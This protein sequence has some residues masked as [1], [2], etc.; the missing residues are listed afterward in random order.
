MKL[1]HSLCMRKGSINLKK[2]KTFYI[3][4]NHGATLV[5]AP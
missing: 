2:K 3:E 4:R 1:A 5:K